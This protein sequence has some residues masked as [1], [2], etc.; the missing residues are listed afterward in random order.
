[1]PLL[2]PIAAVLLLLL[3]HRPPAGVPVNRLPIPVH[4][5]VA[6]T[7]AVGALFTVI[8]LVALQPPLT[9]YVITAVP[10]LTP[11]TIPVV[12]PTVA[13]LIAPEV[14][15]PVPG[16]LSV[17]LARTHTALAP[18]ITGTGLTLITRVAWQP[19]IA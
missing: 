1:M 7:I 9:L 3:L 17:V 15:L 16:A 5:F 6:P 12:A 11:D 14:Q 4:I 18:L 13:I 10:T 19:P 8:V 2:E